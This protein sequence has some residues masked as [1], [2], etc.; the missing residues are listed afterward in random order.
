MISK[1]VCPTTKRLK[2]ELLDNQPSNTKE[3]KGNLITTWKILQNSVV[4]GIGWNWNF[5]LET[6]IEPNQACYV[7]RE[8]NFVWKLS[9]K[10]WL[11]S[12]EASEMSHLNSC[13]LGHLDYS[14]SWKNNLTFNNIS[15]VTCKNHH[16]PVYSRVTQ[17]K[18]IFSRLR[19]VFN[20]SR[21]WLTPQE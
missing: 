2:P 10:I 20:P 21:F 8:E 11:R 4:W 18:H 13:N 6:T 15:E 7:G 14:K 12:N 16:L 5:G 19:V 9:Q 3:W 17:L 1:I